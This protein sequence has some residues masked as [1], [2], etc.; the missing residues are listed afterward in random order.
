MALKPVNKIAGL[1]FGTLK[2][3]FLIAVCLV[4]IEAY[5]GRTDIIDDKTKEESVLYGAVQEFALVSVPALEH[6]KLMF[7]YAKKGVEIIPKDSTKLAPVLSSMDNFDFH[8]QDLA[9]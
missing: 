6:S 7:D 1:G 8:N 3:L 9:H 4:L 2:Y 5:D